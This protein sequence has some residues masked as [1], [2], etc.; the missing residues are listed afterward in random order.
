MLSH[1][2]QVMGRTCP[3]VFTLSSMKIANRKIIS[4]WVVD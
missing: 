2:L 3:A 1:A 4:F